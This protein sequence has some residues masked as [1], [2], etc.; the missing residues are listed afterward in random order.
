MKEEKVVPIEPDRRRQ[1]ATKR[2]PWEDVMHTTEEATVDPHQSPPM[3]KGVT[4]D[5][6]VLRDPGR[7]ATAKPSPNPSDTAE[8][9]TAPSIAAPH[10]CNWSKLTIQDLR[11]KH[12]R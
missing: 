10:Q 2:N 3:T 1:E 5:A 12:Q 9:A 6:I 7:L 4:V 11:L 8:T